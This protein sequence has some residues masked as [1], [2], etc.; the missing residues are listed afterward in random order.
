MYTAN[1]YQNHH[2][3]QALPSYFYNSKL[4]TGILGGSPGT[5]LQTQA[6]V[7]AG[8]SIGGRHYETHYTDDFED[9]EDE[10]SNS[11]QQQQQ[12]RENAVRSLFRLQDTRKASFSS[13]TTT[14]STM[15]SVDARVVDEQQQRSARNRSASSS[16]STSST[17][18]SS[19]SSSSSTVSQDHSHSSLSIESTTLALKK[20]LKVL[21]IDPFKALLTT[22]MNLIIFLRLKRISK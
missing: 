15:S 16:S 14:N 4:R 20:N 18:T 19:S 10:E 3:A 13:T 21:F 6:S 17:S 22:I 12:Q 5:C 1:S 7:G 8:S 9:L 11:K 2:Q